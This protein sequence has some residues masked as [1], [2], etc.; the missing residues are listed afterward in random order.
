MADIILLLCT[1]AFISK[2]LLSYLRFFQQDEYQ[3]SRFLRWLVK[4]RKFD[5]KGSCVVLG[6]FLFDLPLLTG[7]GLAYL[8]YSEQDP[9][10]KGKVLL[11]MTERAKNIYRLAVLLAFLGLLLYAYLSVWFTAFVLIQVTPLFLIAGNCIL[12]P[13]EQ[14]KQKRFLQEA[15]TLIS[16][17]APFVIGITGSFGKTST[18]DALAKILQ[19]SLGPTFW[20]PKSFNTPMGITR[21]IRERLER[22]HE[23]AVIEMGA[24]RRGSIQKLCALTPPQAAIITGVGQCHLDRFGSVENV[25]I[26]KSE[27]ASKL[28]DDGILVCNGD[29]A[30]ARSIASMHPRKNTYLYGFD[31]DPLDTK[32]THWHITEKGTEFTLTWKG[33]TYQGKTQLFGKS[34]L[35]NI[36]A[37]F[38]MACALGAD[39]SL[40]LAACNTLE[41]VD[42]RLQVKR[43]GTIFYIHDG[44]NSNPV[45][46]QNALNVMKA[47][48][49]KRR[50]LMT[51]GM[52]ELGALQHEENYRAAL[53][54]GSVCDLALIV[55][56][57]NRM[58]LHKGFIDAGM[59]RESVHLCD[60]RECAFKTIADIRRSDDIILIENDLTD[61]YETQ[62]RF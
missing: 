26:A 14:K 11:K 28:P 46:F 40:V 21:E 41:P 39:P 53:F 9:R 49:G 3:A 34:A 22:S 27:L 42:N 56:T 33:S 57:T 2:R 55:G 15:K 1:Y 61:L 36:C 4:R 45:G 29:D 5:T 54:A 10:K 38:T 17:Y 23:Y 43:D 58:A 37:A 48:P 13:F 32:I 24:Y 7:A 31:N 30:G 25:L 47:L 12:L 18:K 59:R 19:V 35:S 20:P 52:I 16:S 44:Y 62:I 8:A 50:I 6:G 60:T 51:P